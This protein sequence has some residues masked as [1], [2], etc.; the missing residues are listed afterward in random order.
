MELSPELKLVGFCILILIVGISAY[1]QRQKRQKAFIRLAR[2]HGF[3]YIPEDG[4]LARTYSFLEVLRKGSSSYVSD[5]LEGRYKGH[6][7][8]FFDYESGPKN[9]H[10]MQHF[11]FFILEQEKSFPEL[12]IYPEDALSKIGQMFGYEDIDFESAEFSDAFVVRSSDKRFAYDICNAQM[13]EYLLHHRDFS[14]EIEGKAIALF[15]SKQLDPN[16][17]IQRLDHLV[18][19]RNH[20]PDY[21]Y[22][23]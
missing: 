10:E 16:E 11:S 7:V 18:E 15:F 2:K 9:K 22:K 17:V 4:A 1:L 6:F 19:I 14:I 8:R 12:R 5:I 3:Q 21:L 20:F 23:D 13:I